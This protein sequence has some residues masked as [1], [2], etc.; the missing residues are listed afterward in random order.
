MDH[1]LPLSLLPTPTPDRARRYELCA[2]IEALEAQVCR[3][4]YEATG[5]ELAPVPESARI[6]LSTLQLSFA[7]LAGDKDS[8]S[9]AGRVRSAA[10]V[11]ARHTGRGPVRIRPDGSALE[12][13]VELS[14]GDPERRHV[15]LRSLLAEA[16]VAGPL[17]P[18][19]LLFG[20]RPDATSLRVPA[21]EAGHVLMAGGPGSGRVAGLHTLLAGLA[22][23]YAP[24]RAHLAIFDAPRGPLA[25]WAALPHLIGPRVTTAEG[26]RRLE[27]R[28]VKELVARRALRARQPAARLPR[29]VAVWNRDAAP[30]PALARI[31]RQGAAVGMTVVLSLTAPG[32]RQLPAP[33]KPWLTT[34]VAF[35]LATPFQSRLVIQCS[36]AVAL[37]GR[38]DAWALTPRALTRVQTADLRLADLGRIAAATKECSAGYARKVG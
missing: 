17:E 2:S 20:R 3:A 13:A 33:I 25:P 35:R 36:R 12:V 7:R 28:L 37:L 34:G 5:V 21:A 15:P 10:P 8:L 1:P 14:L 32:P 26:C 29:L 11:I 31:L 19:T 22:F 38:G 16:G 4:V 24:N 6:E 27:R 18:V 9:T 23:R 30:G